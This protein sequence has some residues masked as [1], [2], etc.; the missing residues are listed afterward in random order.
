MRTTAMLMLTVQ[1]V[2]ILCICYTIVSDFRNLLIPNWIIIILISTFV[3]FAAIRPEPVSILANL[4]VA[5]VVLLFFAGF[6][7]AGWVAGGDVKF[8]ASVALW[9]GL[10]HVGN[11]LLLTA[12]LGSLMALMLLQVKKYGFLVS[13]GLGNN[14]LFRRVSALAESSQCPYG[15]AIGVA[16]L[17][18][19]GRLFY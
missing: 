1:S 7:V 13:G 16:A 5:V 8:I 18:S 19:S 4:G 3:I 6:F 17:L 10:E 14:W 2:Y 15:V 11:F 12:L 9:M